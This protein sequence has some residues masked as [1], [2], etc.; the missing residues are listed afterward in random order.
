MVNPDSQPA[1]DEP[2]GSDAVELAVFWLGARH[3]AAMLEALDESF[4]GGLSVEEELRLARMPQPLLQLMHLN[5]REQL[6]AEGWLRLPAGPIACL[7]LILGAGGPELSP[8]QRGYLEAL[9]RQPMSV[10]RVVDSEPGTGFR[11]RDL[12]DDREP[13]HWVAEPLVSRSL[14]SQ[15]GMTFSSRL[16][17]GDPWRVARS[18]YPIQDPHLSALLREIRAGRDAPDAPP[19]RTLRSAMIIYAWLVALANTQPLHFAEAMREDVQ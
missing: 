6:L 17:P 7:E 13:E 9:G 15:P 10:Y 1:P 14:A 11:L 2:P 3:E 19:E 5:G 12:L 16:I 8:V 4:M 18:S